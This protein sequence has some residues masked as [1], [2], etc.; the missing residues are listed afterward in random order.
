MIKYLYI[1][2]KFIGFLTFFLL[3]YHVSFC[4]TLPVGI[5][6]N[7]EDA[8][9]RQQLLGNDT[10][11][12]SYLIRPLNISSRNLHPIDE[13]YSLDNFRKTLY[14]SNN[15][16]LALYALPVVW[17]Q[18]FNSNHPHGMNDG[19]MVQAR[20]YQTQF[21]AGVYMKAG[22]LSIQLRPEFVYAQNKDFTELHEMNNGAAFADGYIK[23]YNTVDLPQSMGNGAYLKASWGQ[24]SI[25]L[26]FDPV[27]FGLSN[28]NL[29]WG[30]GFRNSLLMTNNAAGFKHLTLNT[31]RPI[32]TYIG[33][34]EAQIIGGRLE[35]SD[36]AL[37]SSKF[38]TKPNDW[39][40]LA[41]MAVT[42]Q[43]KWL[44]NLYLGFDR[45]FVVYRNEMGSSIGD[46]FP[47]FS[48][49]SKSAYGD[50]DL[51]GGLNSEDLRKRDQYASIFLR[52]VLPESKS[53][54]YAQYGRN[55]HPYNLREGLTEPEHSRA[56]VLG[57]RKLVPLLHDQEYIQIGLELTQLEKSTTRTVRE[58]ESWYTHYQV[59]GGYTNKGQVIGAGIG[60]GSNMQT[61][62]VSWVKGLDRLGLQLERI[63]NNNDFFYSSG[64]FDIRKHW[65]D[66]AISGNYDFKYKDFIVNTNLTYIRSLNYQYALEKGV[67]FWDWNKQDANNLH[68]KVGLMYRW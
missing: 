24:S 65:I 51:T 64:A 18:Q 21:S 63:V 60:P 61:L 13:G 32:Q 31:T 7:I 30:P 57:F 42:W 35:Q 11:K 45:S 10:S 50:P 25:R 49:L 8:Y 58:G 16:K 6:D 3:S 46:Y 66:L 33:S 52:W 55:D 41:A 56:Y 34:F 26:N 44:P 29:W 36:V 14:L 15:Q 40:Y 62:N 67:T 39:R 38:K 23:Y 20:G 5:F 37:P 47:L 27:S 54:I 17:Q 43:P 28:E 2:P 68:F 4:Q 53:E 1:S 22:P 48:S 19:S 59:T 12:S 9:R